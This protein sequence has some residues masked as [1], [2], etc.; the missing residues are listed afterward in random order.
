MLLKC[1][2][3]SRFKD[4]F[5]DAAFHYTCKKIVKT[6]GCI[7]NFTN[8]HETIFCIKLDETLKLV[9]FRS[10]CKFSDRKICAN[11]EDIT[12]IF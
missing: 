5:Y 11:S 12:A 9:I 4:R 3:G 1:F 2:I 6:A 7:C 8:I 10:P